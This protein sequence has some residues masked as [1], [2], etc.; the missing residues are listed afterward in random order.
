[1]DHGV[2]IGA[3]ANITVAAM[4]L[5]NN[6]FH[7]M[8][9]WDTGV[10]DA[11]HHD[12]V[13]AF[14]S[15]SPVGKIQNLYVYNNLFDGNQ[16][17][18]CVTAW[19]FLEGG[20]SAGSTPWTD[21]TGTAYVWNNVF[22]GSYDLGNGQLSIGTGTGHQVLNN[23]I[24]GTNLGLNGSCLLFDTAATNVTVE[25]NAISGCNQLI[26]NGS[27]PP[28][29]FSLIDYNSYGGN[30]TG[31]NPVFNYSSHNANSLTAWRSACKCD[32]HSVAPLGTPFAMTS[33]G[34]PQLGFAGIGAGANLMPSAAGSLASLSSG[35]S[36]GQSAT[37][38]ARPLTG[39]W[40]AGAYQ[41]STAPNSPTGVTAVAH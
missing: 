32:T 22:I 33:E 36:A 17:N 12:G 20:S 10:A 5:Y 16:G 13:H 4:F 3:G 24:M 34:V 35:T 21:G 30:V 9:N 28:T 38:V 14:S 29:S 39:A 8:A 25:N 11:Y 41:T 40:D 37:P 23:T 2:A 6:H 18:C 7:D 27:P 31:G 26:A 15:L 1:M 19:V